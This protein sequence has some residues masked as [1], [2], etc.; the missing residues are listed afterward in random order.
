MVTAGWC[1]CGLGYYV[2][3][4][5]GNGFESVYGHMAEPPYV[6]A[7]EA[8]SKGDV[9][10]PVGSTG[11]STGPHVHFIIDYDGVDQDPLTYLPY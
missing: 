5:H 9:I 8:V 7:G 1:N 3:I 6:T 4:D 2:K 11:M 10:G